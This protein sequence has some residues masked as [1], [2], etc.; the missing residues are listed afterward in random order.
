MKHSGNLQRGGIIRLVVL[1][2][3]L[4]ILI[5]YFRADIQK[6]LNTPGI[7]DALLTAIAWIQHSLIWV[8][9]K[10]GQISRF[11]L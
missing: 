6:A 11:V 7:R 3:A 10:L 2:V 5:A 1:I 9:D 8:V 4:L